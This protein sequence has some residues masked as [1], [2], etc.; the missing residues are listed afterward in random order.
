MP[1]TAENVAEEFR[2]PAR[3]GRVRA[4]LA[5]TRRQGH[6]DGRL[7]RGDHSGVDPAAK[8][9]PGHRRHRRAPTRDQSSRRSASSPTPFRSAAPSPPGTPRE[10]T[11]AQRSSCS[12]RR[13]RLERYGLSRSP[14]SR[15][16]PRGRVTAD[17]GRRPGAGHA[18]AARSHGLEVGDLDVVELNEAFAAQ[19]PRGPATARSP[20]DA[21]H[22]NPNGGAI[23]LGHPLGAAGPV[24]S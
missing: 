14:G 16:P 3:P 8:G 15:G 1:E 23:A 21:E 24:S 2:S 11:T 7:A 19:S 6:R 13:P 17:H 12:P 4:A 5:A 9:R 20:D 18:Q 10:S 22:V